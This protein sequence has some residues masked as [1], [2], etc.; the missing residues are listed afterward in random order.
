MMEKSSKL[1]VY[2][3]SQQT[4]WKKKER[5]KKNKVTHLILGEALDSSVECTTEGEKRETDY[6]GEV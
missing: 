3:L 4:T 5:G 2:T 6:F 1:Q